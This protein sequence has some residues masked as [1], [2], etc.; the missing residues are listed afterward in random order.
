MRSKIWHITH[1]VYDAAKTVFEELGPG[2]EKGIYMEALAAEF[3]ANPC[4]HAEKSPAIPV[5]YKGRI[6]PHT[7]DADFRV[8]NKGLVFIAVADEVSEPFRRGLYKLLC[9]TNHK[10]GVI[11][12]FGKDEL[13]FSRLYIKEELKDRE[14][15]TVN[16]EQIIVSRA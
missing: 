6:L 1:H 4:I 14:Q 9:A 13:D 8:F 16:C 11:L 5:F 7:I 12:N 2:C 10:V 15:I 3:A